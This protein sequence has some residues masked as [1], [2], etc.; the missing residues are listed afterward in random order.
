METIETGQ[1]YVSQFD[2]ILRKLRVAM[3]L[4]TSSRLRDSWHFLSEF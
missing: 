4:L 3:Y 1:F 2:E